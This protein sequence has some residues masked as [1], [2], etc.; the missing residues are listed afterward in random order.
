MD[1]I[2]TYPRFRVGDP[3]QQNTECGQ[4]VGRIVGC[5]QSAS[6]PNEFSYTVRW[7][8]GMTEPLDIDTVNDDTVIEIVTF[9]LNGRINDLRSLIP[10]G[11]TDNLDLDGLMYYFE[12]QASVVTSY[13]EIYQELRWVH[14]LRNQFLGR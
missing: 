10:G 14:N 7:K 1:K 2:D 13:L 3:V 12:K 11:P 5:F 6:D 4:R 9:M 8:N